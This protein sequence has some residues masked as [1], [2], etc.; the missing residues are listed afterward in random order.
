MEFSLEEN[1]VFLFNNSLFPKILAAVLNPDSEIQILATKT[2]RIA[3]QYRMIS[4][5]SSML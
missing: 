3:T 4:I 1:S 2:L 5:S